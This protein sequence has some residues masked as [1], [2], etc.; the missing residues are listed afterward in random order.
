MKYGSMKKCALNHDNAN[1]YKKNF[2]FQL[3]IFLKN[4]D[5]LEDFQLKKKMDSSFSAKNHWKEFFLIFSKRLISN[6]FASKQRIENFYFF[7]LKKNR[8]EKCYFQ[9]MR[10]RFTVDAK[11]IREIAE[12]AKMPRVRPFLSPISYNY[13]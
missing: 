9:T 8:K 13:G 3:S 1:I 4:K 6:F 12:K 11:K 2:S 5:L 10:F 7:K